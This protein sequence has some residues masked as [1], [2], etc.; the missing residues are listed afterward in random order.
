MTHNPYLL[1]C[2]LL[3]FC[4]KIGHAQDAPPDPRSDENKAMITMIQPGQLSPQA[5][6]LAL[7]IRKHT[8]IQELREKYI[9]H[10]QNGLYSIPA[11]VKVEDD[12]EQGDFEKYGVQI[13]SDLGHIYSVHIP[14]EHYQK[15]LGATGIIYIELAQRIVPKLDKAL[16]ATKV[17]MVHRGDGLPQA[18][19]GRG[20]VV[21]IIDFGFDY[22]HPTFYDPETG[23]YRISCVWEQNTLSGTP[24]PGFSY[25]HERKSE[26]AILDAETDISLTGHGTHVASIAVGSGGMLGDQ[27]RGVAYESDIVLVSLNALEGPS[28][29]NTGGID[30]MNYIFQYAE[31]VGKPA[32]INISQGHH[33]GPHDGTSLADQAIDVMTGPGRIAVGAVGN[34]G[35]PS[36][37]FLHFSHTFDDENSILSYLLCPDEINAGT[38]F[39]DIWGEPGADFQ[40][41]VEIYNPRTGV[42]EGV[43]EILH[44]DNPVSFMEGTVED[45]EGHELY[46]Q[47]GIE[48]NPM[49]NRPHAQLYI[50]NTAQSTGN[51]VNLND[52]L[53][54]D[55][56][57]LRFQA[58]NGTVHAYAADNADEAF[59][60]D[61]SGIGAAE[62]IES[63]RVIGG[64]PNSTMGELG[65]TAQ[66]IISVGGFTT[67]TAFTNTIGQLVSIGDVPGAQ[68][69]RTS[70]GPTLDG[71]IKPDIS[72]PANLIAAAENSFFTN[73]DMQVE[74]AQVP[75]GNGGFWSYSIRRGTSSAAP[76]VAGIAAL[77][78][79][80]DPGLTPEEIKQI[81]TAHADQDDFTASVPNNIWGYGKVNAFES[82]LS[83]DPS[84][85]TRFPVT[86]RG[87]SIYPNPN[88]GVFTIDAD[89]SGPAHIRVLDM[90]GRTVYDKRLSQESH[91]NP[92]DLPDH[93]Q[94]IYFL[95]ITK[96]NLTFQEKLIVLR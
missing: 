94:G 53:N 19:S 78:L 49:N 46:Y 72:A 3:V 63:T 55:F 56:A 73:A 24:P 5:A 40:V 33:T 52:L 50:E 6:G 42:R 45:L 59:F 77:M 80:A 14:V 67:K 20:V 32:V 44:S 29:N 89:I 68:Y 48:I 27:F 25:G 23:A 54:N 39:V 71:R 37:F 41:G 13:N 17:D 8:P 18:Y 57:L 60:T 51:D 61:L 4:S 81:L 82:I 47:A 74:V 36:G 90:H 92:M 58:D 64:N 38:A 76:V 75:K 1:L 34:E 95:Q 16:E 30:G 2:C 28:G 43:G 79:E 12:F 26:Q 7:D 9:L 11:L 15:F 96:E 84:T 35:D 91:V 31:S 85:G 22:T 62:F 83:L 88:D 10:L 87:I 65:G 66:S 70:R 93:F 69:F 86:D 21:G